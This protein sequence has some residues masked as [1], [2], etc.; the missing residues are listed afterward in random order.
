MTTPAIT[1]RDSGRHLCRGCQ[2]AII[3]AGV[4]RC[5]RCGPPSAA[6]VRDVEAGSLARV[7]LTEPDV[8]EPE[9]GA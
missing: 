5:D 1:Y 3:A 9:A 8:A 7:L 2:L 6:L 4:A